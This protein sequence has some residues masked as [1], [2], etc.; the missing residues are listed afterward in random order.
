MGEH[1]WSAQSSVVGQITPGAVRGL[2]EEPIGDGL[3]EAIKYMK[4]EVDDAQRIAQMMEV[5]AHLVAASCCSRHGHGWLRAHLPAL[6]LSPPLCG[7]IP[8]EGLLSS[9]LRL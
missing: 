2:E 1:Q 4:Q 8:A 9:R 6:A 3:Q 7:L 5:R